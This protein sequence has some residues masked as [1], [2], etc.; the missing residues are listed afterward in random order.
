MKK[1]ILF[2]NDGVLVETEQWYFQANVKALKELG[3]NLELID[4]YKSW[5]KVVQLGK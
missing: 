5:Q 4:T 3:V 1:Y 2:D